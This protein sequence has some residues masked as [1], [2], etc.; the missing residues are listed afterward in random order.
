MTNTIVAG[1]I[2]S[3]IQIVATGTNII[4]D[5]NKSVTYIT[6]TLTVS[7]AQL[8]ITATGPSKV[9]GTALTAG[10]S[11]TNFTASAGVNSQVVTGVTLTPNAAGLS[12]TTAAG[13]TY[14]VT[15]SLATGSNGFLETNYSVTYN[16]FTGTVGKAH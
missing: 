11:T 6:Q 12:A 16:A 3:I 9:Y 1:V 13:T 2:Y 8:I 4:S 5:N 14:T 15:P 10:T 7:T